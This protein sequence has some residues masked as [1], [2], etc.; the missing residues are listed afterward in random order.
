MIKVLEQLS[1]DEA[2]NIAN[3]MMDAL[4]Q[5]STEKNY[6][7]HI[8]HF[9][10]R[11]QNTLDETQF[12]VVCEVYQKKNGFFGER[13]FVALFRRPDSIA[14]IWKQGYSKVEGDYVA[15]MVMVIEDGQYKVDHA[16]VF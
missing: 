8:Q 6:A 5:A 11:A 14:F 13:E 16:F 7:A 9:S 2:L 15:E 12:E 10:K 1:D 4:M 3:Q